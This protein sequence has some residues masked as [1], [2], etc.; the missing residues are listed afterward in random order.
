MRTDFER[1]LD[2]RVLAAREIQ[3]SHFV[4]N[5]VRKQLG[6]TLL[7]SHIINPQAVTIQPHSAVHALVN[8]TLLYAFY[9]QLMNSALEA[10]SIASS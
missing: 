1:W 10:E 7:R 4:I 5:P 6:S 8:L 3:E 2:L 9:V